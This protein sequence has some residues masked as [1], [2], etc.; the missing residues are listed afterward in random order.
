MTEDQQGQLTTPGEIRRYI[1]GGNAAFT[2]RS[3]ETGD[4]YTYKVKSVRLDDSRDWST[5][6]INKDR[7]FVSVLVGGGRESDYVYMGLLDRSVDGSYNLHTT[8]KSR[9][10]NQAPSFKGLAYCWNALDQGCR[11][12]SRVEFFHEGKCCVCGRK[13]TDPVSVAQGIGPECLL[14]GEGI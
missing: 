1:L 2:L 13:L 7:F 8:A 12:P 4:R 3:L 11:W 5:T 14:R 6:N 10:S 9:V